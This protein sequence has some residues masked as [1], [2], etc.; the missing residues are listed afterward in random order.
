MQYLGVRHVAEVLNEL[1]VEV[2][3]VCKAVALKKINIQTRTYV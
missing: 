2:K 3:G 1:F